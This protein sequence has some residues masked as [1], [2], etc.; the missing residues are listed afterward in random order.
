MMRNMATWDRWVRALLVAP[1][2][3]I[4]ALYLGVTTIGGIVPL[5]VGV[6]M[7]ATAVTGFCPLYRLLGIST[8]RHHTPA[9]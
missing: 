2:L 6:I 7:L 3:A 1:M 8:L 5:V 9:T 4:A